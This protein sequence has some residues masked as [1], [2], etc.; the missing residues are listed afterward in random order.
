MTAE[1]KGNITGRYNFEIGSMEAY[2]QASLLHEGDRTSDLRT[3][4]REILGDLPSYS[5]ADLSFGLK[6]D[7]WALNFYLKNATDERAEFSRF[8][9]CAEAVCGEQAY[10]LV[11]QPRTFG[12]RFSQEF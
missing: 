12:V 10:T 3:S 9:Q 8:T 2:F 7:N 5:M 11:T 4:E 6:R 1:F